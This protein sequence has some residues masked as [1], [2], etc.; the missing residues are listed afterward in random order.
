MLKT[1][2]LLFI[3]MFVLL[4]IGLSDYGYA[5]HKDNL[6]HGRN[7]V[8]CTPEDPPPSNQCLRLDFSVV[9]GDGTG[10]TGEG[11]PCDGSDG[12]KVCSDGLGAYVDGVHRVFARGGDG[13]RVDSNKGSQRLEGA[14]GF[15][16][17]KLDFADF[18][19]TTANLPDLPMGGFDL[20][21]YLNDPPELFPER[22]PLCEMNAG[23]S[24]LTQHVGLTIGF[25]DANGATW[26]L[27]Y[28]IH[29]D[30]TVCPDDNCGERV[31]VTRVG[32]DDIWVFTGANARLWNGHINPEVNSPVDNGAFSMPFTMTIVAIE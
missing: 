3:G 12:D 28:G 1:S 5:C 27:A 25:A 19:G 17:L 24:T 8:E 31:K 18:K 9:F 4:F 26:V 21:I 15:R 22:I 16:I 20:R 10:E 23:D 6:T 2:T 29:S 32:V 13:F 11:S 14:G 7:P 30:L